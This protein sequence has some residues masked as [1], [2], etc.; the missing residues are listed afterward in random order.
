MLSRLVFSDEVITW[1]NNEK[2][3]VRRLRDMEIIFLTEYSR[4]VD[5]QFSYVLLI[6]AVIPAVTK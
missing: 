2:R 5:L 4:M 6:F 3:I 1:L